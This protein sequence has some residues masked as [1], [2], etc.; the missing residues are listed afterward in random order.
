MTCRKC[1][2][3]FCWI[4]SGPWSDHGTQWYTCNRYDEKAGVEAR[5]AQAKS[6]QALERYLHVR[7]H[8]NIQYYNRY[9]N[10]EQSAKLDK[11]LYEK[12]EKKMELVQQSS[13]LSW[14]EVQF[15]KNAVQVLLEARGTLKWTY[16]FAYYLARNNQTELFEDNQR[17][18]EMVVEQ[19]SELLEKPLPEDGNVL[20]LKQSVMNKSVYVTNRRNILLDDTAKGLA[21]HRWTYNV[22]LK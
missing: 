19:L 5:D 17:D 14:I 16:C 1:K 10:H 21:E 15:L 18:L 12:T 8:P 13:A 11:E 4:C 3:E 22:E 7:S 2:H 20:E 9:A 6:R